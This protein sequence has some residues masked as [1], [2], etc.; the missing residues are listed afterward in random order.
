MA[1][2]RVVT[3]NM[4]G[5]HEPL[6]GRLKATAR[7][8]CALAPDVVLLQ[9]VR[10]GEGLPL[11]AETL[12][13]MLA[14]RYHVA[15]A[16]AIAGDAGVFGPNAPAGEEGLAILSVYPLSQVSHRE[17]PEVRKTDRRILLTAKIDHFSPAVYLHV[18]HLTWRLSDGLARE[19]QVVAIDDAIRSIQGDYVHI[20]GGDLNATPD[21]DEIRFLTGRHTL[22]CRRTH[23]QDA[24]A[25]ACPE[26]HGFTWAKRNP[27]TDWA[28][29]LDRDRRIDYLLVGTEKPDRRGRVKDARVVLDAPGEDGVYPSDHFG[30]WAEIVV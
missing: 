7:G 23:F 17:L 5:D 18:T 6:A 30:V 25:R 2:L 15:Y 1:T 29:W 11:T 27:N 19:R 10:M 16:C 24:F 20:L 14:K 9:E 28:P 13:G 12:A 21:S 26:D 3:L 4:W 8:L 22:A